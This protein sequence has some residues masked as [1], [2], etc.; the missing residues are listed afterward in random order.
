MPPKGFDV[1]LS[2][3]FHQMASRCRSLLTAGLFLLGAMLVASPAL[4]Q[5][6]VQNTATIALTDGNVDSNPANNTS[7]VTTTVLF[8][9]TTRKSANTAGPVKVGDTIAYTLTTEVTGTLATAYSLIDT[10]GNGLTL[11][12]VAGG[13]AYTCSPSGGKMTCTLPA[14]TTPGT[15]AVTYTATV[16]DQA[17]GSVKNAVVGTGCTGTNCEVTIPVAAPTM[18]T[19]KTANTAGPVKVGDTI[20]YTLTTVVSNS[21]LT[22]AYPL[23]DALGVGL[24]FGA[25]TGAGGH[26][27]SATG[28]KL[29]CTLPAGTVPGTYVVTY[30]ATVNSQANGTVAN[31]VTA[32]G[33]AAGSCG[34]TIP[35]DPTITTRKTA[36]TA[37]PVA[38]GD[39][40]AYTLTTTVANANLGTAYPLTDTLGTGLTLG[41]VTNAGAHTC[42]ANGN[43]LNCSLP[44]GTVPGTYTMTYTATVNGQAST[45]GLTN[46]V[47]ATG[48]TGSCTVITPVQNPVV[49]TRKTAGTAGPVKVGDIIT[50]TLTTDVGR[51]QLVKDYPLT[52][53]LG[54]G[55]TFGSVTSAGVYTCS[56]SGQVLRC[57]LPAGTAVGSYA[58]TYTATVNEQATAAVTNTVVADGCTSNCGVSVPVEKPATHTTKTASTAGPVRVGDVIGYTLTTEVTNSQLTADYRL[59]DTLGTGLSFGAV[60]QAGAY[61]CSHSGDVLD[62]SLPKGTVPGTYALTYSASVNAQATS[63]GVSNKVVGEGCTDACSV[64][65][66]VA[67]AKIAYAKTSDARGA[68]EPGDTI[69]YAVSVQV[70]NSALTSP[71]TLTDTLGTGLSFAR[72]DNAGAFS[73][74]TNDSVLTCTLPSGTAPGTYAL[75]YAATVNAQAGNSVRNAVVVA[76]PNHPECSGVCTVDVQVTAPEV[77]LTKTAGVREARIGDLVPYTVVVEN[78]GARDLRDGHTID[79]PPVGFTYVEGSAKVT[80]VDAHVT[81]SGQRPLRFDGL[82]IPAGKSATVTYVMRIGAGVRPGIMTNQ[83][84][85]YSETDK[86]ISNVATASLTVGKDPLLDE[87]LI[88]GT[89]FDD[90]DGDG[91][92]DSAAL[93]GLEAKGGFAP[94]AYVA[95]STLLDRGN[96]PVVQK[97]AS[98][99][100]LHGIRIGDL[101][102]RQSEADPAD[103]HKVV[104]RQTLTEPTFTD[105]FVLTNKQGITVRMDA[106]GKTAVEKSGD[107]AKGLTAAV[108]SVERHV[109]KGEGGY[110]V[111]YVIRNEGIDEA[112]IPGVRLASV[113]GLRV[114]TDQYGRYHLAGIDGGAQR[115]RNFILK[116]DPSTLPPGSTFTTEN[117]LL[118]RITPGLPVRFDWGVKLPEQPAPA[119]S[120]QLELELGEVIFAPGS[121]EVRETYRPSLEKMAAKVSEHGGGDVIIQANGENEHLALARAAAVRDALLKLLDAATARHVTV[122]VRGTVDH[123]DTLLAGVNNEGLTLGTVLF[124]TNKSAIRPEFE[125]LLK[126]IAARLEQTHGGSVAVIG[127]ADV[128]GSHAYN[129]AL[130]MRRAKAVYEALVKR[131]SPE[132]RSKVRVEAVDDPKA[133]VHPNHD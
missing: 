93:T 113:E 115:G 46:T 75:N 55:L 17:T 100:L 2:M 97:D 25:V 126:Q 41:A 42:Q 92:Q 68:V 44:A 30:T 117:P 18:A 14:G 19:R 36:G 34:V 15:Y 87:S 9:A 77:R 7:A 38:A 45:A 39:T 70:S 124:D 24:T 61:V 51:S 110:V 12:T 37:G 86:P 16:N 121:A 40:I 79:N 13:S 49:A 47:T 106:S 50:Y 3:T 74:V 27:C 125:P 94:D 104:I 127:H 80:G 48:C 114:E 99:P 81:V 72:I 123:A 60:T 88:F 111:D 118:R 96:G 65:T 66:P 83:V 119:A 8:P 5:Q 62:C 57:T 71:H 131:L 78:V 22:T 109:A 52:D 120:P 122:S 105:D 26:T 28:N 130:G 11:G 6:S 101:T 35:V 56:A 95:G 4:A 89:V 76:G 43:V 63:A 112:G 53:T 54:T 107:A 85:A 128:R 132:V 116:V 82:N 64:T 21:K 33:C 103:A 20:T 58:L 31:A 108:P 102:G 59:T 129:A 84:Q 1:F 10:P 32:S 91:W 67:E 98:A 29:N 73:C 69:G 23:A 90:R 133:P